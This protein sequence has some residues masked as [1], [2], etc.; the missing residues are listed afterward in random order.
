MNA[1]TPPDAL[2]DR[3]AELMDRELGLRPDQTLRGRLQRCLRDEAAARGENLMD[4]VARL[5]ADPSARQSLYDRLTVQETAFFRHPG[6]FQALA[7]RV[8]PGID[9]PA[10]IWSAGCSNGQEPYSLAMILEEQAAPGLVIATDV[11]T[12]ALR[13]TSEASYHSRELTGLSP[14][15]RD[16]YLT[17]G[18]GDRWEVCK[19]LR[20]R[21]TVQH[22]NLITDPLP[23]HVARCQVVFCRNVLIYFSTEHVTAFLTRL[24]GALAPGACLFLGYAETIWQVTHLF[25]P[26]RLG[27]AFEY[28]RRRDS[29]APTAVRTPARPAR[30]ARKHSARP[31]PARHAAIPGDEPA[32]SSLVLVQAGQAGGAGGD[33]Q[34]AIGEFRRHAFLEPDQP[35]A[36]LQL[37]LAL[38]AA[39][40]RPS[41]QRAYRAARAALDRCEAPAVESALGGYRVEELIRLLDSKQEG[42]H[43]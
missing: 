1:A 42:R 27:D 16:R 12:Q 5:A 13:R 2:L 19:G 9:G 7:D 32:A 29:P 33:H 30:P 43:P 25:E 23:D 31:S 26:V 35:I 11:S 20:D 17:G 36:H 3:A 24:A 38:E 21:V 39:G 40:D 8:L 18:P 4:Y 34:A 10:V 6:Q 15:R 41:A 22:H 37:G 28:H 14:A